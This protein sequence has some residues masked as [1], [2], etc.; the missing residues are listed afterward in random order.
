MNHSAL[1]WQAGALAA[2]EEA[3]ADEAPVALVYNGVSHA[4]MLAS[5][6]DLE[7]FAIGFTLTEG[8]AAWH[9]IVDVA[10]VPVAAGVEARVTLIES[11][12]QALQA[13]RRQLAGRTGCGLCGIEHLEQALPAIAPIASD[14]RTTPDAVLAGMARLAA[15]QPLNQAT[16][17]V[18]AAAWLAGDTLT[19][20]EDVG[21]H[22]ALDKLVGALAAARAPR[23]GVLLMTSR[24]SSEIVH[25][26]ASAGLPI[27]AAI[28]A[29]TRLAVSLA[30]QAGIAL[31]GFARGERLT[32]YSH[33]QRLGL[34]AT[35]G[36]TTSAISR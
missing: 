35:P 2:R 13:R 32:V 34:V 26:A 31:I 19:V 9:E 6:G 30:E 18:H 36:A 11:R 3:L 1:C 33:P 27:V 28:S 20:R 29:P 22:N 7:D 12:F 10:I 24:A 16:G 14:F 23:D 25:K 21:R 8:I 17:A 15:A 5:P 4:V